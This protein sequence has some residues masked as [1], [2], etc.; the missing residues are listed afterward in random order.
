MNMANARGPGM[1]PIG[2]Q[3]P[4]QTGP[5]PMPVP[6]VGRNQSMDEEDTMKN[7]RK[8]FAGMSEDVMKKQVDP[9]QRHFW[10][11]TVNSQG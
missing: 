9:V 11:G 6:Q 8:T 1:M 7:L 5:S 4:P 3:G 2:G 10:W